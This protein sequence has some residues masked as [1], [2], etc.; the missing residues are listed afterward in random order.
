LKGG[1]LLLLGRT[2]EARLA[3]DQAIALANTP[4]EAAH[5]RQHLDRLT[6]ENAAKDAGDVGS[7]AGRSS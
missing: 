1:L 7:A 2:E 5:I 6:Q 4:A 3:F